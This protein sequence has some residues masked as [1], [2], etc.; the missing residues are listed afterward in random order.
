MIPLP[1]YCRVSGIPV[2]TLLPEGKLTAIFDELK[3]SGDRIVELAT[4]SSAFYGPAAVASDIAEAIC[5]DTKRI[6][7]VSHM[8][9]GQFDVEGVALSLPAIIGKGG[10][11]KTLEPVLDGGQKRAITESA[12]SIKSA[13]GQ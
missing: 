13:I 11:E 12:D 4:R 2:A 8:L 7:S 1:A 10:I 5:R 6:M 3:T 9:K